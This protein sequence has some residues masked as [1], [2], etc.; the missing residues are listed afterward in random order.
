MGEGEI[1]DAEA[2]VAL[3]LVSKKHLFSLLPLSILVWGTLDSTAIPLIPH[4]FSVRTVG[5]AFFVDWG[6]QQRIS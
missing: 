6:T 1:K 3:S 2:E 4:C 5:S